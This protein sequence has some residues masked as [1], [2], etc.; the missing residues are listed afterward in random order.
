MHISK[1]YLLIF[2]FLSIYYI[3]YCNNITY[4]QATIDSL[5]NQLELSED[6]ERFQILL[7]LSK[8]TRRNN[9]DLGADYMDQ[10]KDYI[11]K[12]EITND[13]FLYYKYLSA[14]KLAQNKYKESISLAEKAN[15][16]NVQDI[17]PVHY[18]DILQFLGRAYCM[19]GENDKAQKIHFKG[20]RI[21]DS[22]H[23]DKEIVQ[24]YNAIGNVYREMNNPEMEEKY[25]LLTIEKDKELGAEPIELAMA[26]A[27]LAIFY[28]DIEKYD[29]AEKIFLENIKIG[30]SAGSKLFLEVNYNNLAT[31]YLEQKQYE[32]A[33]TYFKKSLVIAEEINIPSDIGLAHCNL[34]LAYSDLNKYKLAKQHLD[35]GLKIT[36]DIDNKKH[37]EH[38][39]LTSFKLHEKL[40][41]Y[42]N[43]LVYYKQYTSLKDSLL[44][45][46]RIKI[47][48]ELE[49][50]YEAEKKELEIMS[51]SSENIK[52]Q[53]KL[54][55][56][57]YMI[58][59]LCAGL[60]GFLTFIYIIRQNHKKN[61]I[62]KNKNLELAS[63]K[64][65][66]LEQS[67][68]ITKLSSLIKG[69][70][71]ERERLAKELHDGLGGL[72]AIS[73]S[74]LANLSA[75]IEVSNVAVEESKNL[76]GEA[77]DQVRQIS[78]NLMPLDLEKFGLL[79]T[80]KNM[81]S[82]VNSQNDISIDFR[83]YNFDLTL[84]NELG[85][86]IYR[87]VQESITNI[88]KHARAKNVF[89]ELIQHKNHLSLNIEDD[90]VGFDLVHHNSGNG[91]QNMRNRSELLNGYFNL[92][93]K[94]GEG[95]S[96]YIELP[97]V[98][99]R[100]LQSQVY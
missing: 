72:L 9:P 31:N 59:G 95:T 91:I 28:T 52:S 11:D 36:K 6:N 18:M 44:N 16:L 94:D 34:G 97:L 77:Y 4:S 75:E 98:E 67:K 32:K 78:H 33:I 22:L 90:G 54:N 47:V 46:K 7:K 86:N 48:G 24:F 93:S 89:I 5:E 19:L 64:I 63:D 88:L 84:K 17:D 45:E 25:L 96:I 3:G 92:E 30:Q 20:L 38:A 74:K 60:L 2:Y 39:L 66:L 82:M 83:T 87:I 85:L 26:K 41:D 81:I 69:Q 79:I 43:A 10:A 1:S 42:K 23:L 40:G 8:L 68:E 57:K 76:V 99:R 65:E 55:L 56:F 51:L 71:H 100:V 37:Y 50:K 35:I 53:N 70:E 29:Q 12:E 61:L 15:Q 80:L 73:H 49:S 21:A 27:N 13:L 62:I 58:F 14:V